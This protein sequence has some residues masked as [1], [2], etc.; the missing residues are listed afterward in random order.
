MGFIEQS[1]VYRMTNNRFNVHN[2]LL[3][4]LTSNYRVQ[5]KSEYFDRRLYR[6]VSPNF[7]IAHYTDYTH[8]DT[9]SP[10]CP[11]QTDRQRRCVK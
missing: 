8:L 5:S 7:L 10:H 2:L 9:I 11:R 6:A 1:I 3:I 4:S